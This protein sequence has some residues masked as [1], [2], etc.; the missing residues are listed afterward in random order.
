MEARSEAS[1][2]KIGAAFAGV[3]SAISGAGGA[4]AGLAV[5]SIGGQLIQSASDIADSANAIGLTAEE[6]QG[7]SGAVSLAG[8]DINKFTVGMGAVQNKMQDAIDGSEKITTAFSRLGISMDTLKA[9]NVMEVIGQMA[10]GLRDAKNPAEAQA[11]ALDILGVRQLR[12][13]N[14]LKSGREELEKL[15]GS[16]S[17]LSN[18][19]VESVDAMGD[20]WSRFVND[21]KVIGGKGLL[22]GESAL[23]AIGDT[24]SEIGGVNENRQKNKGNEAQRR[25]Q[26]RAARRKAAE[27]II[28]GLNAPMGEGGDT[29]T[30]QEVQRGKE[31]ESGLAKAS[32]DASR[33]ADE[34]K[35]ESA[36]RLN[37]VEIRNAMAIAEANAG[38]NEARRDAY[39]DSLEGEAKLKALEED[40]ISLANQLVTAAEEE[41]AAIIGKLGAKELEIEKERQL[42]NLQKAEG[43]KDQLQRERD[44]K[45][46]LEDRAVEVGLMGPDGRREAMRQRNRTKRE[47]SRMKR[48]ARGNAQEARAFQEDLAGGKDAVKIAQASIDALV[49]AIGALGVK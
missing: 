28:P 16:I 1:A 3:S 38:V 12:F 32:I 14:V 30:S 9:G 49:K 8:V 29:R 34:A 13:V 11:A 40:R 25:E 35:A 27:N 22:M 46:G 39:T 26:G 23:G 48:M 31:L 43:L 20:S 7:L 5:V 15:S 45:Q 21:L 37:E 44:F 4:I 36:R 42:Q 33:E 17:R 6:F 24:L 47:E 41:K 10:D 2:K 18:E 19:E